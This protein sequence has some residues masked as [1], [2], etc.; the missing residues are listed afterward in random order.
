MING[1]GK[2]GCAVRFVSLQMENF[3][4]VK[5]GR[6]AVE[7]VKGQDADI[8]GLYGQNGSGKSAFVMAMSLL[9]LLMCGAEIKGLQNR[10]KAGQDFLSITAEFEVLAGPS[11]KCLS[12]HAKITATKEKSELPSS[13]WTLEEESLVVSDDSNAKKRMS[14][15]YKSKAPSNPF[16]PSSVKEQ[17]SKFIDNRQGAYDNGIKSH[18][19]FLMQQER[20]QFYKCSYI[21]EKGMLSLCNAYASVNQES[22]ADYVALMNEYAARYLFVVTDVFSYTAD[23]SPD[24]IPI[25]Y[26]NQSGLHPGVQNFF[27]IKMKEPSFAV[28]EKEGDFYSFIDRLNLYIDAL[29]PGTKLKAV[30]NYNYGSKPNGNYYDVFTVKDGYN[31]PIRYESLGIRKMLTIASVLAYAYINPSVTLCVDELDSCI[32]ELVLQTYFKSF[33]K[34]GKGQILF[35][36]NNLHTLEILDKSQCCFATQNPDDRYARLK[37]VKPNNNLRSLYSSLIKSKDGGDDKNPKLFTPLDPAKLRRV[38]EGSGE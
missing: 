33:A 16:A 18:L 36:S 10:I 8:L 24:V 11:K 26:P 6:V 22:A 12:Y 31:V 30:R 20:C 23:G 17:L 32:H 38:F 35:T 13:S 7:K 27:A 9:R 5:N 21:F 1:V 2:E 14:V 37:Y 19:F 25:L 3:G 15:V 29:S 28:E 34:H 4:C